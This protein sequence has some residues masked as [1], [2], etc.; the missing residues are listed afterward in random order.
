MRLNSRLTISLAAGALLTGTLTLPAAVAAQTSEKPGARNLRKV[1]KRISARRARAH[2]LRQTVRRIA[3]E[4]SA[5]RKRSVALAG[6]I[7]RREKA[8][9]RLES[10]IKDA[11]RQEKQLTAGHATRQSQLARVLAILQRIEVHPPLLL[12]MNTRNPNN[13]VR[14][15]IVIRGL[16]PHLRRQAAELSRKQRAL[17]GLRR[18][19]RAGQQNAVA[20]RRQLDGER[21]E[22]RGLLQRQVRLLRVAAGEQAS[23]RNEIGT[24]KR[25]ARTLQQLLA[26]LETRRQKS[27]K[28]WSRT[29][30]A[31]Q[32]NALRDFKK[33][34]AIL[35]ASGR[36][37]R[38]FGELDKQGERSK[39]IVVRAR[40][41]AAVVAPWD[42]QIQF[43][44]RFR[45][46]GRILIIRHG[47]G[48]HSVLLGLNR[49]NVVARQ[50]VL[51]GEPVGVVGEFQASGPEL[52]Y[53]VRE[54]GR[55][56]DPLPWLAANQ[57]NVR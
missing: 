41:N 57:R 2:R 14:A 37:I 18:N 13:A 28:K 55:P 3:V 52:Y 34:V 32:P 8:L 35:P 50:W 40:R 22:I 1:E 46:F 5:L 47:G 33:G 30:A 19:L 17:A 38:R 24:L 4:I 11:R 29:A 42:G 27:G 26:R 6:K 15:A 53:E 56:V 54:K 9:S 49:I 43:A 10:Q 12:A 39:G 7:Q 44:G 45:N 20:A 51:A 25:K 36:I 23:L 31:T 16:A 48:Y 21:K